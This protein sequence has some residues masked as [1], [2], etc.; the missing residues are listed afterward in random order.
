MPDGQPWPR[1]TIVTPSYNQA[2]YLE[3]TIRSVL[4]QGYPNLE[5]MIMDG[6]SDDGTLA[7]IQKYEPWLAYWVSEP[8]RGQYH[9]IN[10]GFARATG[11][12]MAWI[13]SDDMYLPGALARVA[14][15]MRK[16][17]PWVTGLKAYWDE[18]GTLTHMGRP[19]TFRRFFIRAGLYE[20]RRLGWIQQESTFWQRDLWL[21]AGGYVDDRLHYAAD[22]ELWRRLATYAN[23]YTLPEPL[24][25][26]RIHPAQK[27]AAI[28]AYYA[29]IDR[30]HPFWRPSSW[31][32][33][34]TG[35][36]FFLRLCK[37]L[38]S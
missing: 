6:G 29:E 34:L 10:K 14:L 23:L 4:L 37:R 3:A 17:H 5:Y 1:I 30:M 16:G 21:R 18:Q 36:S 8:D 19:Q 35:H 24:A 25:G 7:I 15:A 2:T 11:D 28:D 33:H 27:T 32:W 26:F 31:L 13:N 38:A 22:Y 12:I 9:A 20:G